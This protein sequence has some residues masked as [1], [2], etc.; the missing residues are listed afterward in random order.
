MIDAIVSS[1]RSP[2]PSTKVGCSIVKDNKPLSTGY[3]GAP[4]G[5]HP[6]QMPWEREGNFVDT[7]YAY[8]VHSE[9][10]AILNCKYDLTNAELYVTLFCCNECMKA[11]IQS[12]I[13]TIHYLN[14]KYKH[15][16]SCIVSRKMAEL[17]GIELVEHQWDSQRAKDIANFIENGVHCCVEQK[18]NLFID[19]DRIPV[20]EVPKDDEEA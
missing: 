5:I 14:D 4:R 10:N 1:L 20:L 17:A 13:K 15:T 9:L 16:D 3:N 18:N 11:V 12:G 6:S 2:D 8:V 19:D 7:K